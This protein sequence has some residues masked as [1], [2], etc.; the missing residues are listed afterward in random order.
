MREAIPDFSE[1]D[2][3]KAF[4]KR[5]KLVIEDL[6]PDDFS[7]DLLRSEAEIETETEVESKKPR[8]KRSLKKALLSVKWIRFVRAWWRKELINV[9]VIRE[10]KNFGEYK[11]TKDVMEKHFPDEIHIPRQDASISV[12]LTGAMAIVLMLTYIILVL[13]VAASFLPEI[14]Q[15]LFRLF[16]VALMPIIIM[17]SISI[18]YLIISRMYAKPLWLM[19]VDRDGKIHLLHFQDLHR[20]RRISPLR[21]KDKLSQEL[22]MQHL[23]TRD[24]K[25]SPIIWGGMATM[26]IATLLILFLMVSSGGNSSS[27][28]VSSTPIQQE[29]GISEEQATST[30]DTVPRIADQ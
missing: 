20:K 18:S 11:T 1:E 30:V 19:K 27:A 7:P 3:L 17:A 8:R 10:G 15:I 4:P 13:G 22:F 12:T 26:L 29:G 24:V 5:E 2:L 28:S 9:T 25:P 14:V 23:P 6:L 21:V 16:G